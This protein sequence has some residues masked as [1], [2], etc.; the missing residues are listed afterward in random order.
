MGEIADNT[1]KAIADPDGLMNSICTK[2]AGGATLETYCRQAVISFTTVRQWIMEDE[3]RA[4]RLSVAL[5][6]RKEFAKDLIIAELVA[7]TTADVT[8]AFDGEGNMLMLRDMPE[9]LRKLVA[10]VKFKELFEKQGERGSK[11]RVHVG[12]I[13]E[14][15]FIDKPRAIELFMRNLAMLVDK[16]EVDLG[17]SL[18]DL[19]VGRKSG[20]V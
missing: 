8:E 2:I 17:P 13:I 20:K 11:A 12:N 10:G 15:K 1:S 9:R 14:I 7:F 16:H 19:I 3:K 18:A 6:I 5:N 4:E